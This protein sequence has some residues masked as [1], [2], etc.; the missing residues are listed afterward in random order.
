MYKDYFIIFFIKILK[1]VKNLFYFNLCGYCKKRIENNVNYE[2]ICKNC[3]NSISY[4]SPIKHK[5]TSFLVYALGKYD[6]LLRYI[7]TEKYR[8]NIVGYYQLEKNIIEMID[9]FNINFDVI[10]P[11]PK[12]VINKIKHQVD[13]TKIIAEIISNNYKKIIFNDVYTREKKYDQAGKRFIDR[14]AMNNEIF[15][16]PKLKKTELNDKNILIIDDVYTT[17]TTIDAI[18]N[19]L[20]KIDY[21]TINILV[22]ARK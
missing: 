18:I 9:F 15:F 4:I 12:T 19:A 8:K 7:V 1:S 5:K 2:F 14:I 6:G 13:Q 20:S 11:I 21:K 17:G 22:L 10:I 3:I 16:I